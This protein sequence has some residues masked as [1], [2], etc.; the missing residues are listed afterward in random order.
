M[1]CHRNPNTGGAQYLPN[2]SGQRRPIRHCDEPLRRSNPGAT[3]CAAP[4]TQ[5][6]V[7]RPLDCFAPLAMTD[8]ELAHLF[9]RVAL[10]LA[11]D[12]PWRERCDCAIPAQRTSQTLRRRVASRWIPAFAGMTKR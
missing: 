12:R 11:V 6:V 7:L 10:R 2:R 1:H 4:A 8:R 9:L 5:T 3:T